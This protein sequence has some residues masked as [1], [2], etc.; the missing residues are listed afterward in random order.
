MSV[1]FIPLSGCLANA[2]QQQAAFADTMVHLFQSTFVPTPSNVLADYTAAEATYT[3]YMALAMTAWLDPILSPGSGFM[4]QSPEVQFSTG[5][6]DPATPNLIG[7]CYL[8]DADGALRMTVIFA[9][10]IPMELA[11]QGIPLS[12]VY[13][14]PTGQ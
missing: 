5:D 3:G 13:L 7:G 8:V 12:F 11:Y 9:S 1:Q 14:F 2:T 10:V 6:T 4:I